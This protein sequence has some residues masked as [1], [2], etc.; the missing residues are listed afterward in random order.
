MNSKAMRMLLN[1]PGSDLKQVNQASCR[2]RDLPDSARRNLTFGHSSDEE[3]PARS[4]V[5]VRP[6]ALLRGARGL[7]QNVLTVAL[8]LTSGS[9]LLNTPQELHSSSYSEKDSKAYRT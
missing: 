9:G 2:G 8:A 7:E 1:P 5:V 4:A 3:E 6:A